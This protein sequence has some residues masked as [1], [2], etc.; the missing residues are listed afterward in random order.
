[1]R[2][3]RPRKRSSTPI[4]SRNQRKP[5][6]IDEWK[7]PSYPN[8]AILRNGKR[9]CHTPVRPKRSTVLG[10]QLYDQAMVA[11]AAL[12]PRRI[13][14][15]PGNEATIEFTDLFREVLLFAKRPASI[16]PTALEC[17][18]RVEDR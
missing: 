8:V 5:R 16:G 9:R 12:L 2:A 13:P 18:T 14:L 6:E 15:P 3:A 4:P 11:C 10:T 1:M 7:D 17:E